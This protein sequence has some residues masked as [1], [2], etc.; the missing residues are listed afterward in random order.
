VIDKRELTKLVVDNADEAFTKWR[1]MDAV[2]HETT[3][4]NLR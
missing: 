1:W 2:L 3:L 4:N